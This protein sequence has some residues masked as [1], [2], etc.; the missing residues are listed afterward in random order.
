MPYTDDS[1]YPFRAPHSHRYKTVARIDPADH[2]RLKRFIEDRPE[3]RLLGIEDNLPDQWGVHVG[4]AS[5]RVRDDFDEWVYNT[6]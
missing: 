6:L 2:R 3:L 1:E 4:C 5:E